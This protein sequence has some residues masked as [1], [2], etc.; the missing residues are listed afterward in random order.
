MVKRLIGA[1][2]LVV[3]LDGDNFQI[4]VEK[5]D[6]QNAI[7]SLKEYPEELIRLGY[8]SLIEQNKGESLCFSKS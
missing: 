8:L 4:V 1:L 6:L 2:K 5:E 7:S 3:I